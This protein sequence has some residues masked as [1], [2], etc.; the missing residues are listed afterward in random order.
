MDLADDR[1]VTLTTNRVLATN[2]LV[3]AVTDGTNRLADPRSLLV[4]T[5]SAKARRHANKLYES[6]GGGCGDAPTAD[7]LPP[8]VRRAAD[9]PESDRPESLRYG[10][11]VVRVLPPDQ[12]PKGRWRVRW[13]HADQAKARVRRFDSEPEAQDHYQQLITRMENQS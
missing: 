12:G 7:Y 4:T 2:V 13:F 5:D 3:V 6:W 8:S 10:P 1:W 9:Y 11:P